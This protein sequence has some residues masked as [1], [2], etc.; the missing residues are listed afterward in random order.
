MKKVHQK[1][2]SIARKDL[3]CALINLREDGEC[4]IMNY[5]FGFLPAFG[6]GCR[7]C[8]CHKKQRKQK[9]QPTTLFH[10]NLLFQLQSVT[11]YNAIADRVPN[12]NVLNSSETRNY[13]TQIATL[14]S[15]AIKDGLGS[16]K[17]SI[18]QKGV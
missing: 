10:R 15:N 16:L 11:A 1:R 14:L 17:D 2:Q 18:T 3:R 4:I 6:S 12:L 9:R 13:K 7:K 5:S 8:C